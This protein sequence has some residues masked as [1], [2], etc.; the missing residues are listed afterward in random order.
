[1]KTKKVICSTIFLENTGESRF[2]LFRFSMTKILNSFT[3]SNISQCNVTIWF[4]LYTQKKK[5]R[6]E[7][8]VHNFI[9]PYMHNIFLQ[10]LLMFLI[11]LP[12]LQR[13]CI[14]W[15][16]WSFFTTKPWKIIYFSEKIISFFSYFKILKHTVRDKNK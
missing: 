3:K 9:G 5:S 13:K 15:K 16:L 8:I 2:C 1:M 12:L 6:E 11:D 4:N 14:Y 10:K 7:L